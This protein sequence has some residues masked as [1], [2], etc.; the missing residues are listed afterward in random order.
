MA[1]ALLGVPVTSTSSERPFSLAGC[2]LED[3]RTVLT[4]ETNVKLW[5][6]NLDRDRWLI[7]PT[8]TVKFIVIARTA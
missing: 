7:I 2:T 3:R 1:R 8:W 4:S 6:W 5:G